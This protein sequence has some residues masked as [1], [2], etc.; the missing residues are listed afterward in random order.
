MLFVTRLHEPAGRGRTGETASIDGLLDYARGQLSDETI[1]DLKARRA[2]D[3]VLAIERELVTTGS[4]QLDMPDEVWE[5]RGGD[6]W[7]ELP[8]RDDAGDGASN[9]EQRAGG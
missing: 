4:A 8:R 7:K 2:A 6:F 5:M 3:L 9:G 1:A